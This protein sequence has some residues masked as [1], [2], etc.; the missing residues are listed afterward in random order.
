MK[1]DPKV[2]LRQIHADLNQFEAKLQESHAKLQGLT[3]LGPI[4]SRETVAAKLQQSGFLGVNLNAL[5]SVLASPDS[6]R[7]AADLLRHVADSIESHAYMVSAYAGAYRLKDE[8]ALECAK[9]DE[10]QMTGIDTLVLGPDPSRE[11]LDG[12]KAASAKA[13]SLVAV[14]QG[15]HRLACE[16][17]QRADMLKG[18]SASDA[19]FKIV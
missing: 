16:L 9:L 10:L 12:R 19:P 6:S 4:S 2:A 15:Q 13:S 18:N 14:S 17:A 11:L 5:Q 3:Q 1:S 8:L 7:A